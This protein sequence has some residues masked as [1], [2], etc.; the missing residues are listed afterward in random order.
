MELDR[1]QQ[2]VNNGLEVTEWDED[3]LAVHIHLIYLVTWKQGGVIRNN[4]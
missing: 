2:Q 1:F 4:W 3:L